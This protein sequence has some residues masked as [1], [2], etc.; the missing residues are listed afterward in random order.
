MTEL[1]NKRFRN[2][3]KWSTYEIIDAMYESQL[4]AISALKPEI[5]Q[6]V[7]AS[8]AAAD[9]LIRSNGKLIYVGA[10][11][12]GRLAVQDGV[13]LV[14][15]FGWPLERLVFCMA[16]G[17]EALAVG[18]E[19][20]EDAIDVGVNDIEKSGVGPNDVVIVV[21]ASGRTP[22]TLAALKKAKAMGALTIG[23]VNN[24]DSEILQHADFGI[25][26]KTGS[27]LIAGSTRMKAGTAQKVTLNML[28]TAT[29]LRLGRTY[30]GMMVD[31]IVSNQKLKHRAIGIVSEIASCSAEIAENALNTAENDIKT[32]VL[33][34]LGYSL[35]QSKSTL[36][37]VERDLDQALKQVDLMVD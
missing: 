16:G 27:E 1:K 21:T 30:N 33:V 2:I 15:T 26:L 34:S 19:G 18:V 23:I 10:G 35:E 14:P 6:I 25:F 24:E 4:S 13:E 17:L 11:T 3:E 12:S 28:S 32:A 8:E 5:Q 31:M 36:K 9:R 29:M 37:L 22:F 7:E 20:A